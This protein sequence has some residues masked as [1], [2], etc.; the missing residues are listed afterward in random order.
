MDPKSTFARSTAGAENVSES[1]DLEYPVQQRLCIRPDSDPEDS[2][3][4]RRNI[5]PL[6]D[7]ATSSVG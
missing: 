2:S 4:F 7:N 1:D 5:F 3:G 6:C